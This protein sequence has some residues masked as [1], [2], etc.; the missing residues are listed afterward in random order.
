MFVLVT[1]LE[2]QSKKFLRKLNCNK[3]IMKVPWVTTHRAAQS[4]H[5]CRIGGALSMWDYNADLGL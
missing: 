3:I 2:I 5:G 4:I 1:S